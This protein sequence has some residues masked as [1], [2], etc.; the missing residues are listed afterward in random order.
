MP[1]SCHREERVCRLIE[2]F[3]TYLDLFD[4]KHQDTG[5][6]RY[7]HIR[8]S[9]LRKRHDDVGSLLGDDNFFDVL[10]ATLVMWRM[11]SRGAKLRDLSEIRESFRRQE[12]EIGSLWGWSLISL[13]ESKWEQAAPNVWEIVSNLE[14]GQ[15]ALRIVAGTKAL[16]HVLPSLV[17]PVDGTYTSPFFFGTK[18]GFEVQ[19]ERQRWQV[20]FS[21]FARIAQAR[22][23]DIRAKLG[24]GMHTSI[25]KVVDNA[26]IAFVNKEFPRD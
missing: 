2:G 16:H 25:S 4:E 21:G 9:E 1:D 13:E 17:P 7:F 3:P 11:H 23:E 5:P 19:N 6:S 22:P 20:V 24:D 18:G 12:K 10:Y 14:V 8:A 15:Q 26:I